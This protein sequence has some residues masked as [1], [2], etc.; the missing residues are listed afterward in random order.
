MKNGRFSPLIFFT[1]TTVLGMQAIRLLLPLLLYVVSDNFGFDSTLAGILAFIVF[2]SSFLGGWLRR[3][4]SLPALWRIPALL[5]GLCLTLASLF[6]QMTD[7]NFSPLMAAFPLLLVMLAVAAFIQ[8]L[9]HALLQTG[10]QTA[11]F[12]LSFLFALAVDMTLHGLL[13]TYD[14][15]WHSPSFT[16]IL[17]LGQFLLLRT[18]TEP[19]TMPVALRRSWLLLIIGPY[20]FLQLLLFQNVARLMAV[21][22]WSPSLA[23]GWAVLAHIVGVATAVYLLR[24]TGLILIYWLGLAFLLFL[25]TSSDPIGPWAAG[26]FLLGQMGAAGLLALSLTSLGAEPANGQAK[27][28]TTAYSIGLIF[29]TAIT[30]LYYIGYQLPLPFANSILPPIAAILIII[31]TAPGLSAR[32]AQANRSAFPIWLLFL[33]LLEPIYT[34][35]TGNSPEAIPGT[36]YPVRVMTYNLHN[37]FN[38]FGYLGLEAIAKTIEAQQPDI[39]ALQEVSRGWVVNG[40]ADTLTWLSQRLDMPYVSG[41]TADPLLGNALLSRYPIGQ[42]Q[43]HFLPTADLPYRRGF[44][45]AEIIVGRNQTLNV[46]ATHFHHPPD[47]GEIRQQQAQTILDTGPNQAHTII[48]GD[49]NATPDTPEIALIGQAGFSDILADVEANTT[50]PSLN[51][52]RQ[53]DYIWLTSDLTADAITIPRSLASDHLAIAATI[54]P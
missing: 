54:Q 19:T 34:L 1:L 2:A 7:A 36:G 45:F 10:G 27:T 41:P 38:T 50:F 53:I 15:A 11:G 16:F 12:V 4:V 37:G 26:Q 35:T 21:T 14:F 44:I 51:S 9:P 3:R 49:F 33:L 48:M 6:F 24:Q 29:M 28:G 30:F 43:L 46:I 17:F 18:S 42:Y 52:D 22:G 40:S 25:A 47:G 39:V 23:F 8:F 31:I 13:A 32:P 20:L 5:I